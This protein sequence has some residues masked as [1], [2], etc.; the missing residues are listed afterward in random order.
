MGKVKFVLFAI[1]F[2]VFIANNYSQQLVDDVDRNYKQKTAKDEISRLVAE[3]NKC[4]KYYPHLSHT[5]FGEKAGRKFKNDDEAI[6]FGQKAYK[7][8][9]SSV[10]KLNRFFR[11]VEVNMKQQLSGAVN[12]K[13]I[14]SISKESADIVVELLLFTNKNI[15]QDEIGSY[16]TYHK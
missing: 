9:N 12:L 4:Y 10:E 13:S 14:K 15:E 2:V 7:T 16:D 1:L 8:T 11:F 3:L 5:L 6:P